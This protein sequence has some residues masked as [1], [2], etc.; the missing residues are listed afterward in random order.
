MGTNELRVGNFVFDDDNEIVKVEKI[1]SKR[2][3]QWNEEDDDSAVEFT[4]ESDLENLYYSKVNP[5]PVTEEWLLK[6]GFLR[7]VDAVY[8]IK[9][10]H[11]YLKI[12]EKI[13]HVLG[14]VDKY[15]NCFKISDDIKYIHQLQNLYFALTNQELEIKK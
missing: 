9:S 5:I 6:F 4:K 12:F 11:M 3:Q 8:Y 10:K 1:H 7:G 14:S 2:Y 13:G 15:S